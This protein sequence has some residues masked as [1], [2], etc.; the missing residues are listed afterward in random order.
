M[1]AG[2]SNRR[3][4]Y[5]SILSSFAFFVSLLPTIFRR[6]SLARLYGKRERPMFT[7]LLFQVSFFLLI[8]KMGF[9]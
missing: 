2:D 8:E 7:C 3:Y 5:G 9:R 6:V 1:I 4:Y